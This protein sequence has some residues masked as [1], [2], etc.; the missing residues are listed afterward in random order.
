MIFHFI[1][2]AVC[3]ILPQHRILPSMGVSS[4][5]C[6]RHGSVPL[7]PASVPVEVGYRLERLNPYHRD[8]GLLS[9]TYCKYICRH[10][11]YSPYLYLSIT[12]IS[13]IL[14]TFSYGD[15]AL[16]SPSNFGSL[17]S[18]FR[19]ERPCSLTFFFLFYSG[20]SLLFFLS[21]PSSLSYLS[22]LLPF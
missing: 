18:W 15:Y 8:L 11:Q 4:V 3:S 19:C 14:A 9:S 7:S 2:V 22:F 10:F 6:H 21:L 17:F 1:S 5:E 20:R 16:Y 12:W 13:R